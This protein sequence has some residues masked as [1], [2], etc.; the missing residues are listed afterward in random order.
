MKAMIKTLAVA[1]LAALANAALAL[2]TVTI[3][4]VTQRWPW[5]N[6]A[7]ITYTVSDGQD[8]ANSVFY[9][10]KFKTTIGGTEYT[11]D[12]TTDVGASMNTG[13]HTVTWTLPAGVQASDC[14]IYAEVYEATAPSGDDYMIVDLTDGSITYEGLLAAQDDSNGR[15][16]QTE[17]KTSKLVL[18]KIAKGGTYPIGRNNNPSNSSDRYSPANSARTWTTDRDYY[19]AIFETTQGQW[20]NIQGTTYSDTTKPIYG[21]TWQY[22]RGSVSPLDA[23]ASGSFLYAL[24]QKTLAGSGFEGFDLPTEIMFEIADRA[25]STAKFW[26]DPDSAWTADSTLAAQYGQVNSGSLAVVG[27]H[28]A[29]PIG[30]YDTLGNVFEWCLDCATT[31]DGDLSDAPDPWT[32]A[33]T[34]NT[35]TR[36]YRSSG[37]KS[38]LNGDYVRTSNRGI[39][40]ERDVVIKTSSTSQSGFR[41]AYIVK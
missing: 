39:P 34:E 38:Y 1:G 23:P 10:L 30:L 29:N 22:I 15:Y 36:R 2:P 41:V 28:D 17:Y 27:A 11:I 32:P 31:S 6:K 37:Y 19:I 40:I 9:R 7:D 5:N 26:F 13:T 3:D 18:R 8:L 4:S 16:N 33:Y 25:G 24:N 21:T 35:T 14:T 20:N 12:G